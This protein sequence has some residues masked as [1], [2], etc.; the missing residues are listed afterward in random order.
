M[1]ISNVGMYV[2]NLEAAKDFFCDC[3]GAEVHAVYNEEET[4][5]WQVIIFVS[6]G[7]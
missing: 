2:K 7:Q 5:L 1:R 6:I 3:F 4:N